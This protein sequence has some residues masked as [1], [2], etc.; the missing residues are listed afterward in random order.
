M[1]I[2]IRWSID[3][4]VLIKKGFADVDGLRVIYCIIRFMESEDKR[5]KAVV[6]AAAVLFAFF[7]Q[8]TDFMS[9]SIRLSGTPASYYTP[10]PA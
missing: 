2:Q 9:F 3:V 8:Y 10:V 5:E 4:P 7:R 6:M 1:V